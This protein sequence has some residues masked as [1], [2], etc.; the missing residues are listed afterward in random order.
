VRRSAVFR[1][2]RLGAMLVVL[3]TAC[4][5]YAATGADAGTEPI[6]YTVTSGDTLWEIATEK[7]P[8]TED[9]R[10][11]VEAIRRENGLE[12]YLITPGMRL[13]LPR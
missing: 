2:R 6:P 1:R 13:Q 7:Y 5:F 9:P 3:A 10:N 8:P 11:T 12:G 4:A